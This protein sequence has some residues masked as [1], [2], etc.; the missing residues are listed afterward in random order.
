MAKPTLN[1]FKRVGILLILSSLVFFVAA[2]CFHQRERAFVEGACRAEATVT[3]LREKQNRTKSGGII[4]LFSPVFAFRDAEGRRHE[5]SS[6]YF[7]SPTEYYVG[8]TVTAIYLPN[9][10]GHAII[11]SFVQVWGASSILCI[12]GTCNLT[13]GS[14]FLIAVRIIRSLIVQTIVRAWRQYGT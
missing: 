8:Q 13:V 4:L 10:P 5:I 1:S 6:S 7:S 2:L 12:V 9:D 3:K 14:A 11:D